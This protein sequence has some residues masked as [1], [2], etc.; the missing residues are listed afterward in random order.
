MG[1]VLVAK[2]GHQCALP[3]TDPLGDGGNKLH[4]PLLGQV[5]HLCRVLQMEAVPGPGA[6]PVEV[7]GQSG[8]Q[9][10]QLLGLS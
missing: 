8:T 4:Q 7:G 10:A 3:Q 9:K 6:S 1:H 2:K 5:V